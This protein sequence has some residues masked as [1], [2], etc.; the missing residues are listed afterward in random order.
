MYLVLRHVGGSRDSG[1]GCAFKWESP[2]I[3]LPMYI[4]V[5]CF[6]FISNKQVP[7]F[8]P[9]FHKLVYNINKQKHV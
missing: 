3:I 8:L 4:S 7:S 1:T 2:D 9:S 6:V 5:L